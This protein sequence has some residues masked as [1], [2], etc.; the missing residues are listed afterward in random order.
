MPLQFIRSESFVGWVCNGCGWHYAAKTVS[1]SGI[2]F[3]TYMQGEF[4]DHLS[5]CAGKTSPCKQDTSR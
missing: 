3:S 1:G 4:D 5:T 2:A